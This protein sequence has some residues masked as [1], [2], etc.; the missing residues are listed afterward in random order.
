MNKVASKQF[1][2]VTLALTMW[3]ANAAAPSVGFA[4]AKG[5]I[6]IDSNAVTG[7]ATILS[8]NVVE[9]VGGSS[10]LRL[11]GGSVMMASNARVQVFENRAELQSGKIQV[12]GG[13]L[14]AGSGDI[15]VQ[16]DAG[17]EAIVE[18]KISSVTVGA[19]KGSVRV[20]NRK[21]VL[22]ASLKPGNAL[23][24][25]ADQDNQQAGA[26]TNPPVDP[27]AQVVKTGLSTTTKVGIAVAIGT[28]VAVT[29]GVIST[30]SQ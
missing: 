12:Q 4:M 10:E 14:L 17:A 24:F 21:G 16:A 7:N 18:R 25:D 13:T 8:G 28:G 27:N 20:V 22:L 1:L 29:A 2:A 26:G 3:Q 19:L 9:S 30:L 6:R 5:S 11:A 15:R 23:A